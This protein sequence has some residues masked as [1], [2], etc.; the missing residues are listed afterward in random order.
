MLERPA[1]R[2]LFLLPLLLS[3]CTGVRKNPEPK[4]EVLHTFDKPNAPI[5]FKAVK[6]QGGITLAY[7]TRPY[8]RFI[9]R[10]I[11]RTTGGRLIL[12]SYANDVL[13]IGFVPPEVEE[14]RTFTV[15]VDWIIRG[16]EKARSSGITEVVIQVEEDKEPKIL[17]AR[18]RI[19]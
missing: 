5:V 6:G 3:G 12:L 8:S 11:Y 16:L 17:T 9:A 13:D 18:N 1:A 15:T 14:V 10:P 19:D 2:L 7:L 4:F